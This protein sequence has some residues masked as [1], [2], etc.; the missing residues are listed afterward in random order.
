MSDYVGLAELRDV[1]TFGDPIEWDVEHAVGDVGA[2]AYAADDDRQAYMLGDAG[3][4]AGWSLSVAPW[5]VPALVGA[6]V[7][8]GVMWLFMCDN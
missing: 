8:A 1:S 2:Y 3:P 5:F 6:A 7:G 4:F